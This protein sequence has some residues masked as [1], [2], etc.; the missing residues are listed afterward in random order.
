MG[1]A[2]PFGA[3]AGTPFA[4]ARD[5]SG[6]FAAEYD[7]RGACGCP[8]VVGDR[9]AYVDGAIVCEDHYENG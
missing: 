9:I 4:G 5:R 3:P 8:I 1:S 7:G 6:L 2:D